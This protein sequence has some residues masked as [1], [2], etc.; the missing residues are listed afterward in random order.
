MLRILDSDS[1][2]QQMEE[3]HKK[4]YS[5]ELQAHEF[6]S[7]IQQIQALKQSVLYPWLSK[8]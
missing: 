2:D 4:L 1:K 7:P 3:E 8:I 6:T 5:I